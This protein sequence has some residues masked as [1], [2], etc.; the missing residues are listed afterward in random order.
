MVSGRFQVLLKTF[1]GHDPQVIYLSGRPH[2]HPGHPGSVCLIRQAICAI[3]CILYIDMQYIHTGHLC[4]RLTKDDMEC[5][6]MCIHAHSTNALQIH[7][8]HTH[9]VDTYCMNSLE[10]MYTYVFYL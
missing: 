10:N 2:G 4:M 1:D 9:T 6:H 3:Y 5:I 7:R 8:V